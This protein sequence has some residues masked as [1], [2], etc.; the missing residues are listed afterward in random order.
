[1]T[2]RFYIDDS[3]KNDPPV[4][5]LG[6]VAVAEDQVP[7]FEAAWRAA[8]AR[9][10]S[11]PYFKMKDA[12]RGRGVFQGMSGLE[13]T[14]KLAALGDVL[15]E[16]GAATLAVIVR[17]DDY[18]RIFT[19][20]MMRSMD[21]PYQIMFHLTIATAWRL[22]RETGIGETAAFVFDR[23]LEHEKEL[24]ESFPALMR[25][26]EPEIASFLSSQPRH[27]DDREEI[28]LQAADM[29]AWHVRRSWRDGTS[30]LT[31]ASAAGPAIATLPGKHNLFDEK[32]LRFLAEVA[33]G[34]VRR[35]NTVFPYEAKRI[36]EHFD[37]LTTY[38]NLELMEMARPFTSTE[39]ISFPA[40]ETGKYLLVHSCD[41]LSR[42]HLHRRSG[43]RCLGA[44]TQ[45]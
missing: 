40:S 28:L 22:C 5:V 33:T 30:A 23:Q 29:V 20:Q 31:A 45:A 12:H 15:R 18:Q 17:H 16:H 1:M 32:A 6:G 11:I 34:A 37:V 42:P 39:L 26:I 44:A 19:G 7:S 41:Q 36:S 27:A 3:G 35:L 21:S 9:S 14:A 24:D 10:P 13:R 43:M 8:L 4:F 2:L 25:G 38:A